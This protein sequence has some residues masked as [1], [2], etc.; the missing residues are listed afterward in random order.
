MIQTDIV[1]PE[2]GHPL[3]TPEG[4]EI[5]VPKSAFASLRRLGMLERNRAQLKPSIYE[6]LD[7]QY[8]SLTEGLRHLL[9]TDLSGP[10]WVICHCGDCRNKQPYIRPDLA[11]HAMRELKAKRKYQ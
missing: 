9:G 2:W 5:R 8:D 3:M 1:A 7:P 10:K 6:F 4:Q 11:D